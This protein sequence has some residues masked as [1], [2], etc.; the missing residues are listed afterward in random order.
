MSNYKSYLANKYNRNNIC[1]CKGETGTLGT[2]GVAGPTGFAGQNTGPKGSQGIDGPT[3]FRGPTGFT[4][5]TG[6]STGPTGFT[7]PTGEMGP[8]IGPSGPIGY[9]GPTGGTGPTGSTGEKGVVGPVGPISEPGFKSIWEFGAYIPK[10]TSNDI[11]QYPDFAISPTATTPEGKECWLYPSY[12]GSSNQDSAVASPNYSAPLPVG[13]YFSYQPIVRPSAGRN[14]FYEVPAVVVPFK[15]GFIDKTIG[16]TLNSSFGN[17]NSST[18]ASDRS[19]T[20]IIK[21]YLWCPED[22][23]P[24]GTPGRPTGIPGGL[25][26]HVFQWELN[27]KSLQNTDPHSLCCVLNNP[28]PGEGVNQIKCSDLISGAIDPNYEPGNKFLV[29][30]SIQFKSTSPGYVPNLDPRSV[31]GSNMNISVSLRFDPTP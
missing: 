15:E 29:S 11:L 20:I 23:I 7:G 22:L 3:G 5:P 4:G 14:F 9:T 2:S 26:G 12:G 21:A 1:C 30:V 16:L 24:F 18:P 27:W 17:I 28:E 8:S 19:V 25:N 10:I 13:N 31:I 6:G